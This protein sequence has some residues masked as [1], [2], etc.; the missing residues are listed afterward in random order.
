MNN[1]G[2]VH[3]YAF[4]CIALET[5]GVSTLARSKQKGRLEIGRFIST[6]MQFQISVGLGMPTFSND[7]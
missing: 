5:A 2:Y 3:T 1:L 6:S 7:Q 4:T